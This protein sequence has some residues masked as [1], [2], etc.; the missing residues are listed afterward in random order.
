M[1]LCSR[2]KVDRRFGAHFVP[3][4]FLKWTQLSADLQ[5]QTKTQSVFLPHHFDVLR[6][7]GRTQ[8]PLLATDGERKVGPANRLERGTAV[9]GVAPS[10]I[11]GSAFPMHNLATE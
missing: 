4:G 2:S 5:E 6:P 3:R 11:Q 10:V 7:R 9:T 1:I 8:S